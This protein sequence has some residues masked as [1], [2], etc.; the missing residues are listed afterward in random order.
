M[1]WPSRNS[2]LNTESTWLSFCEPLTPRMLTAPSPTHHQSGS[3]PSVFGWFCGWFS[4]PSVFSGLS[5][6]I[7]LEGNRQ[8]PNMS[9]LW[10]YLNL[11]GAVKPRICSSAQCLAHIPQVLPGPGNI[12]PAGSL[13]LRLLIP[14]STMPLL[15]SA[16]WGLIG[17]VIW[18]AMHSDFLPQLSVPTEVAPPEQSPQKPSLYE[19]KEIIPLGHKLLGTPRSLSCVCLESF[20]DT[21]HRYLHT[22]G[23]GI[24][25]RQLWAVSRGDSCL[26]ARMEPPG[27]LQFRGCHPPG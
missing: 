18:R 10:P 14:L 21:C 1:T 22:Q 7:L 2:G 19:P 9:G 24:H 15:Y 26:A 23:S 27:T 4:P 6:F 8:V 5:Q 17:Y 20:R 13:T 11:T 25:S 16:K 3:W 12:H